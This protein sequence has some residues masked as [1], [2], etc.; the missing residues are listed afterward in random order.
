MV[1]IVIHEMR[2]GEELIYSARTDYPLVHG[3]CSLIAATTQTDVAYSY[4]FSFL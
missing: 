1:V 2:I 3:R 4:L